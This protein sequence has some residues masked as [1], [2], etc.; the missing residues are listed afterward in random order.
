MPPFAA[1]DLG[2]RAF[3][4]VALF[5]W[6]AFWCVGL[7]GALRERPFARRAVP[8]GA[9]AIGFVILTYLGVSFTV[10]LAVA[11]VHWPRFAAA[12]AV[13]HPAT[14]SM[15]D[16]MAIMAVSNA[17]VFAAV[18]LALR[19]TSGARLRDLGLTRANFW[20]D[21]LLGLQAFLATMPVVY[22]VFGAAS[23]VFKPAKANRHPLQQM[24]E[25]DASPWSVVL[26]LASA[27]VAAPLA[28]ELLF[29][30]VLQPWLASC[31]ARVGRRGPGAAGP[32]SASSAE[33]A[34][35]PV[36]TAPPDRGRG[37]FAIVAASLLFAAMHAAQMP[38][39]IALFVLS[40]VLGI[41]YDRTGG[42]VAPIT[43]HALFNATS[44]VALLFASKDRP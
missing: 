43:L 41:L 19:A 24:L 36:A 17:A 3:G 31:L 15:A 1:T 25:Q 7:L 21:A 29:R 35:D 6:I 28:E 32:A 26:A 8:W 38:A 37:T 39:P 44:T 22:L 9:G 33:I 20:R 30:G 11:A 4:A 27:V 23:L 40:L 5:A 14:F 13:G 42:L 34:T 12:A 18:P 10:G 2:T 16:Q